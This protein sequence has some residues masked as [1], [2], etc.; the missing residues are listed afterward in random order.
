MPEIEIYAI[1]DPDP[2]NGPEHWLDRFIREK[3]INYIVTALVEA[4]ILP[5]D[6]TQFSANLI[7]TDPLPE[8][9]IVRFEGEYH[10]IDFV[11]NN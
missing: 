11:T 5:Q 8:N 3:E 10:Q 4:G 7:W 1:N 9:L 2:S 6:I